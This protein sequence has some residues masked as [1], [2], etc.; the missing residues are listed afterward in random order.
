MIGRTQRIKSLSARSAHNSKCLVLCYGPKRDYYKKFL[1]EPYP[2]E[3]HLNHYFADHLNTEVV[4]KN[5]KSK[6]DCVDWLTWTFMYRRLTRNP[7]Y[8][9]LL[10]VSGQHI[11][12][13]ISELIE[14]VVDEL[15]KSKC[16]AVENELDLIP[17]NLGMIASYYYIKHQTIQTFS[18]ALSPTIKMNEIIELI[19]N[20]AEFE[21]V[22]SI[23]IIKIIIK[24][25][26][27]TQRG[28]DIK[29]A[30]CIN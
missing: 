15:E 14:S 23:T 29:G 27:Q 11:N 4:S 28:A 22:H 3:S 6:Q 16:L 1:N 19:S 20:A 18:N 7:N 2:V 5:I 21:I 30:L 8:Y 13:Y 9:N 24:G 12:D 10:E 17:L 26:N 25:T